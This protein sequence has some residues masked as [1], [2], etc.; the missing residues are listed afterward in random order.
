MCC[1]I[2]TRRRQ[3]QHGSEPVPVE[4]G[5][6]HGADVRGGREVL[7]QAC[8]VEGSLPWIPLVYDVLRVEDVLKTAAHSIKLQSKTSGA[9]AR[10]CTKEGLTAGIVTARSTTTRG[11]VHVPRG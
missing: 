3:Q 1:G 6:T 4:T 11:L 7:G 2:N 10:N 5:I 9:S 8:E